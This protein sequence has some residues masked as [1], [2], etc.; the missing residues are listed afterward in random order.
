MFARQATGATLRGVGLATS[1]LPD[2]LFHRRTGPDNAFAAT[3]SGLT[4]FVK[5]AF[6]EVSLSEFPLQQSRRALR[7]AKICESYE[8]AQRKSE[9]TQ[10]YA[11]CL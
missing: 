8:R 9:H 11:F 10:E 1:R 7:F 5:V 2:G 4:R 6:I 3:T